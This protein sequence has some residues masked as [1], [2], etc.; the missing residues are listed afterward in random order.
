MEQQEV[1]PSLIISPFELLSAPLGVA[2][3]R[4][5]GQILQKPL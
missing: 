5:L 2:R 4:T 3:V 1:F